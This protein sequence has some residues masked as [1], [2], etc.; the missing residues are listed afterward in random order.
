LVAN[1]LYSNREVFLRELV[2]NAS[3]ASDA[4]D[5]LRYAALTDASLAPAEGFAI[6]LGVDKK[7]FDLGQ[8]H[9]G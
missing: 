4:Y 1:S 6:T 7:T 5:K 8:W 2:S 3:D 9:W